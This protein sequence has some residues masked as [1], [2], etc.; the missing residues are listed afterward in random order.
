MRKLAYNFLLRF[1]ALSAFFYIFLL[2]LG[3][4]F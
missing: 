3:K 1:L 2:A 4:A